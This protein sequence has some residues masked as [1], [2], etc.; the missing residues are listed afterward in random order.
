MW[1]GVEEAAANF[2]LAARAQKPYVSSYW[3]Q[4]GNKLWVFYTSTKINIS[5]LAKMLQNLKML[6]KQAW[7]D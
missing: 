4:K 7:S 5:R 1:T 3:K 6:Y 2:P